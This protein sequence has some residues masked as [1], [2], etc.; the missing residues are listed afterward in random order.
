MT[1]TTRPLG[2][3]ALTSPRLI[4]KP[5]PSTGEPLT[6]IGMGTWQTFNV[7][8]DQP[9]RDARTSVLQAF[10]AAGGQLV[11]SSPMYGSSQDVVGDALDRLGHPERLFSAD[12]VWTR[13]G[14]ETRAQTT[15]SAAKWRI[16]RFDLMQIH[17][18]LSWE[19]HL[20]RLAEMKAQGE[21]RYI[22]VT[23]SHGRRHLEL[24]QVMR[25]NALDFVQLTYN[26]ADREVEA[27]LLPLAREHGMAVIAN[28]PFRGGGL[29]DRLQRRGGPLPGWAGEIGCHN[30]PQ[31]VLKWI[32]SHPAVT[33]AIPATSRVD[34]MRENM[35]AAVG[36]LPDEALRAR[37]L[38]AIQT[39]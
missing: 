37:M 14:D 28:R 7:G 4:A 31:L 2:A 15:V 25:G 18:L 27:R 19:A 39:A 33:C 6:V 3:A 11:D 38:E 21:V 9:L 23:T 34:H 1:A 36:E 5:I 13:D 10:F 29:V 8:S 30:W 12:K 24:E 20:E 32:V 35:G 16:G 22:G 26:P 17:N